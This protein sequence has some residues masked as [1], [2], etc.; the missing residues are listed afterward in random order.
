M[1]QSAQEEHWGLEND[2]RGS[3]Y[4]GWRRKVAFFLFSIWGKIK[5]FKA[6]FP[7]LLFISL[8]QLFCCTTKRAQPLKSSSTF[9]EI[10]MS[11]TT[12]PT[13]PVSWSNVPLS[14]EKSAEKGTF[15][16]HQE[17]QVLHFGIWLLKFFYLKL[18]KNT[19][20]YY[21]GAV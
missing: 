19:S 14:W 9:A 21:Y 3:L 15:K 11:R 20:G 16:A 12:V 18:Y 2:V 1:A 17:Y 5:A 10:V 7:I 8:I 6:S 13:M 4:L